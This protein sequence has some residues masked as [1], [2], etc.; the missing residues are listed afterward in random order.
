MLFVTNDRCIEHT[1]GEMH[2]ES[3]ERLAAVAAALDRADLREAVTLVEAP[4]APLELLA[5]V[6]TEGLVRLI[7]GV[8]DRGGGRIDSDTVVVP[9][10][11]DAA[12]YAAGAGLESIER[13]R[14][15]QADTAFC[16]VRP[17]GHHAT[18]AESMGFCLFNNVAVTATALATPASGS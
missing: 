6:H 18:K 13:L 2:P 10:S 9:A 4:L 14:Q 12:R 16:A 1:A 17:P 5:D 7:Q 15:G 8:S 11:F 3:P